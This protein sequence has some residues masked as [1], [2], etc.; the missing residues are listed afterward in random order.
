MKTKSIFKL[1]MIFVALIGM[2]V[3]GCKKDKNNTDTNSL[4]QLSKD[5]VTV[6]G[7]TNDV[8]TDANTVL[9]GGSSK[10]IDLFPCNATIDSVSHSTV[11]TVVYYVTFNGLNCA[12]NRTRTGNVIIK[13]AV[14][15]Y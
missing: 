13:K 15:A 1:A 8:L 6:E 4:Q 10:S 5:E 14:K 9:S 2:S 7:S 12:G 11:D 3:T